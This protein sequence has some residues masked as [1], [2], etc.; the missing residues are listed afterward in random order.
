MLLE[1]YV[2]CH[3]RAKDRLG[4]EHGSEIQIKKGPETVNEAVR[5]RQMRPTGTS[6][7]GP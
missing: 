3:F 7:G 4:C 6:F 1:I 2:N 5:D